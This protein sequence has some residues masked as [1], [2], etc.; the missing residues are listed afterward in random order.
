MSMDSSGVLYWRQELGVSLGTWSEDDW[1][2]G[3]GLYAAYDRDLCVKDFAETIEGGRWAR[4][5]P[6]SSA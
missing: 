5:R 1:R 4:P 6:A 2:K 3:L